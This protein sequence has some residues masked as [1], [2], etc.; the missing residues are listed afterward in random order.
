MNKD[1]VT[2]DDLARKA[3]VA[4]DRLAEWTKAKLLKPDGFGDGKAPLF[5]AGSLERVA[6]I[7][8]LSDLG[9]G[10]E[11]IQ[12]IIKKVGLPRD[13][14][15]RK[16]P[17]DKDR[18][19]TVGN[20]AE[21]SGVSPRTIK[22]WEDKGIIE[23]DM[24]TE[25]GFRLYSESYVFLCKLIR[26]L[27]LF[28]YTL[29]EVKAVS[30]DVRTLLAIEADPESFPRTEVEKKLEAMLEAIQALLDKMKLLEEGIERWEDLLKKKRKDILALKAKNRKRGKAAKEASDG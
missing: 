23:P 22:H 11:E 2:L 28:G 4:H 5:A 21:R 24:R 3:G 7:Q 18:F 13:E 26:D 10:T 16:R 8:R 14:R 29:D 30:D 27:Q 1:V 15:G 6:F 19:L 12:K 20:L 9:Y 17:P 25:G